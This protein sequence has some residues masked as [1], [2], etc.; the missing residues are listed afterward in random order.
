[1]SSAFLGLFLSFLVNGAHY[2]GLFTA[3]CKAALLI[4]RVLFNVFVYGFYREVKM[5]ASSQ[6]LLLQSQQNH[7]HLITVNWRINGYV[8][9]AVHFE[10]I[11]TNFSD[12]YLPLVIIPS[13][14]VT[15]QS[16]INCCRA[17]LA[18]GHCE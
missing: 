5:D 3:H 11:P 9:V 13:Y 7:C 18:Y 12:F 14:F 17:F 1:V 6:A 15:Y 2:R 8:V 16:R 4:A 10:N